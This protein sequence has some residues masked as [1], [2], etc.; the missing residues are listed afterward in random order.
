MVLKSLRA[1]LRSRDPG[2]VNSAIVGVG[3]LG[4]L[5]TEAVPDLIDICRRELKSPP[6]GNGLCGVPIESALSL[7]GPRAFPYLFQLSGRSGQPLPTFAIHAIAQM[8]ASPAEMRPGVMALGATA[9]RCQ[10]EATWEALEALGRLGP[11]SAPAV[12]SLIRLLRNPCPIPEQ[13]LDEDDERTTSFTGTH[14][15]LVLGSIGKDAAPSVPAILESMPADPDNA[16]Q[17]LAQ[18]GRPAVPFLT[19]AL[20]SPHEVFREGAARAIAAI[21]PR[22]VAAI[23]VLQ[24]HLSDA[25]PRVR[26]AAVHAWIALNPQNPASL[27]QAAK[28][29][30]DPDPMVR[31]ETAEALHD[32]KSQLA[33][34]P[35]LVRALGDSEAEVRIRVVDDIGSLGTAASS[36]VPDIMVLLKDP[37][38]TV[39][40]TAALAIV[41]LGKP[42]KSLVSR[43]VANLSDE[44][45]RVRGAAADVLGQMGADATSAL[46]ALQIA[47]QDADPDVQK[48]AKRAIGRIQTPALPTVVPLDNES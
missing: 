34:L 19:Q 39:R 18:I 44:D 20:Q 24:K 45:A 27:T 31:L 16:V 9:L 43:L 5:A 48:I 12:P 29:L 25:S 42:D 14:V 7:V 4:P 23:P 35:E 38:D 1:G 30:L 33:V 8:N 47:S 10:P 32:G 21:G 37:V 28:L 15:L 13:S 17:A 6:G 40:Q 3:L 26:A 46:P 22:A 2:T 41:A 36:A 11:A